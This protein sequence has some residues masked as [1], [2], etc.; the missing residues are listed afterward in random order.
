[1][2]KKPLTLYFDPREVDLTKKID[3]LIRSKD[4]RFYERSRSEVAAMLL[5]EA[6]QLELAKHKGNE[7]S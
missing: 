7:S 5:R 2:S 1:M 3:Q 4:S 6:L